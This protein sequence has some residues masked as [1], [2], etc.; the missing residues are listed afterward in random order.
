MLFPGPCWFSGVVKS[1]SHVQLLCDPMDYH[2][3]GSSV[4]GMFPGKDIGI[5]LSVPSPGDLPDP[6][7]ELMSSV[8]SALAGAVFTTESPEKPACLLYLLNIALC[9][10]NSKFTL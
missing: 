5:G 10:D 1:Q 3:P 2:P 7:I 4:H 9:I 8:F 6:G